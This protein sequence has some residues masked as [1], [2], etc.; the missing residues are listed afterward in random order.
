MALWKETFEHGFIP[1]LILIFY[2]AFSIVFFEASFEAKENKTFVKLLNFE[3]KKLKNNIA[4]KNKR[5]VSQ[6]S[7]KDSLNGNSG[8]KLSSEENEK[9]MLN[10]I[11]KLE[12]RKEFFD[13]SLMKLAAKKTI[14]ILNNGTIICKEYKADTRKA[15]SIRK[16]K[17]SLIEYEKLCKEIL[18]C[19]E[20][21]DRN[22]HFFDD[23][24]AKLKIYHEFGRIQTMDRGFGNGTVNIEYIMGDFFKKHLKNKR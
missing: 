21:A 24:S 5:V 13:F 18:E 17:C 11:L 1:F 19:I 15:H 9:C 22:E 7:T 4:T 6:I 3:P 10:N 8:I 16:E 12:Y 20:T 23:A 14:T 2:G